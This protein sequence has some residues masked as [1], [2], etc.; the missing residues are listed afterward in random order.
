MNGT[1]IVN[2]NESYNYAKLQNDI[3]QLKLNIHFT[4]K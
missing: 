3:K 4:Q 2:I 1:N